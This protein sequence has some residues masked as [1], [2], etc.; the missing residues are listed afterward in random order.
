[1]KKKGCKSVGVQ[2]KGECRTNLLAG[3]EKFNAVEVA[4]ATASLEKLRF[5]RGQGSFMTL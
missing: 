5:G 3:W 2:S 4:T 1:M